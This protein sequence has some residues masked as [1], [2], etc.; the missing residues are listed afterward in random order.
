MLKFELQSLME[1]REV[2]DSLS[3]LVK[4]GFNYH[5]AHRLL[6]TNSRSIRMDH[7]EQLCIALNCTPDDLLVWE[8]PKSMSNLSKHP[9]K[10][11]TNRQRKGSIL[12]KIKSLPQD[13]LDELRQYIDK[14]AEE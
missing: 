14:L 5:T 7:V 12:P 2:Q 1:S 8:A 9:L 4:A 6:R 13:K 10:K 3:F 11:L